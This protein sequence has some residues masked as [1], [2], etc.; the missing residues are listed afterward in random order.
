MKHTF[1]QHN[2]GYSIIAAIMMIGFLL[3]LTTS[4]LN[5]VLQEMQDGKGR[6]DYMKAYGAAE[7]AVEQALYRIK[8]Y[9]YGYDYKVEDVDTLWSDNKSAKIS[10][11]FDSR[12]SDYSWEL[13][14]YGTDIIPLFWIDENGTYYESSD[15]RLSSAPATMVWNILG[16]NGWLSWLGDFSSLDTAGHKT[17]TGYGYMQ[18]GNF[19][20]Q[21]GY[22]YLILYNPTGST[23]SYYLEKQSWEDFSRPEALIYGNAQVGKYKQNIRTTVDNAEFLWIL[24]YS[25]YSWN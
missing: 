13:E 2:S 11:D 7:W 15:I 23:Q 18:V 24:K 21:P 17:L 10:F 20:S 19:L 22:E 8:E 3:I 1:S 12:V 6:Q 25:I 9:G 16:D 4:T 14:A 5:L